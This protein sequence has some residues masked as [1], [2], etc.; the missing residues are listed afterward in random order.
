MFPLNHKLHRGLSDFD[1]RNRFV[2]SAVWIL[3]VG[4][5]QPY[6][7][8]AA[9]FVG[10]V[11]SGW[12]MNGILQLQSGLPFTVNETGDPANSG[13]VSNDE[14]P[15]RVGNG[16]LSNPTP[17][18]WLDTSAFVLQPAG[19]LGNSGRDAV[20]QDGTKTVDFS[21]F[22]NN[23][24]GERNYNVHFRAEFFNILNNVSF[25]RPNTSV[26]GAAFGAVTTVA[27]GG[28]I[29]FALKFLF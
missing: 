1:V 18:H 11:V 2:A 10:G 26:N 29:Q 14:R 13:Y 7:G 28:Q 8:H 21:L 25:G 6:L 4:K 5:G 15:N 12:Q 22:K 24:F 20:F 17:N 9:G 16:N 19:T 27:P 23:F 3:P